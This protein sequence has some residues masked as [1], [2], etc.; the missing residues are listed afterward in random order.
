[1]LTEDQLFDTYEDIFFMGNKK[2]I[3]KIQNGSPLDSKQSHRLGYIINDEQKKTCNTVMIL[4]YLHERRIYLNKQQVNT[5]YLYNAIETPVK[6]I[7]QYNEAIKWNMKS[8]VD[9]KI[10]SFKYEKPTTKEQLEKFK[11][12][13]TPTVI[14]IFI[15]NLRESNV[16]IFSQGGILIN[17]FNFKNVV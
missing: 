10:S 13:G 16:E 6:S 17:T 4:P 15:L 12:N 5:E 11:K 3:G 8:M 1:M 7:N 9:T 2:Q 14:S